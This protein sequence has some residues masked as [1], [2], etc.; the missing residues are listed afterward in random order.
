[1][2]QNLDILRLKIGQKICITSIQ[3]A[4]KSAKNGTMEW[5]SGSFGSH[6]SYLYP[7][8]ILAGENAKAEFTGITFAGKGQNLDTGAKMVHNA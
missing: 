4:L 6:I 8:T 3:N 2:M 7:M 1:M 5:I